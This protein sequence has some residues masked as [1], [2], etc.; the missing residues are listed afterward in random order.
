MAQSIRNLALGSKIKDNNGNKFI[1][2]AQDHYTTNEVTLIA[3]TAIDELKVHAN[4]NSSI[5]FKN[6]DILNYLNNDYLSTLD[7]RLRAIIKTSNIPY[8]DR[9]S[10]TSY[11]DTTF[12]T[13]A[14]IFSLKELGLGTDGTSKETT[15][16]YLSSVFKSLYSLKSLWSRT[17]YYHSSSAYAGAYYYIV[18]NGT[19]TDYRYSNNDYSILPM[20]N[21][22]ATVLVSDITS[23][24][25]YSFIFNKPPVI[26]N[27]SNIKGNYGSKTDIVYVATGSD[28][29]SLYHYI[30]FDNGSTYTEIKP[31]R[32]NE[33]YTY[34]YV[35]NELK[36]YYCRIKVIDSAGNS[37]TSNGF[38]V[39][40]SS[41]A[42]TVNIVS[43]VDKIVTFKVS[44]LT[45]DIS[46]VEILVNGLTVKTYTSGFDFNLV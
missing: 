12:Q 38:T 36:T 4:S 26:K 13:K 41:F 46:K 9:L 27:I 15:M 31:S 30:S 40:V 2:V 34:S 33:T 8:R 19:S 20:F 6:S 28:D 18:Y 17:E 7:S 45:H 23:N 10:S 22:D 16:P 21:L 43:V 3:E 1:V 39:E 44:C 14:F 35:F 42:P 29:V 24:G 25:Y 11:K 37:V 5:D 32:V